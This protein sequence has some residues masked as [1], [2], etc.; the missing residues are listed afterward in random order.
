MI[1][2]KNSINFVVQLYLI[3][4]CRSSLTAQE[5]FESIFILKYFKYVKSKW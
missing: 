4:K 3:I 2:F 1:I 5:N